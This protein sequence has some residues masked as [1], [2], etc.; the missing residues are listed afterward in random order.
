MKAAGEKYEICFPRMAS[1]MILS[2]YSDDDDD[3]SP[4]PSNNR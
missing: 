2:V 1:T 3:G 4:T